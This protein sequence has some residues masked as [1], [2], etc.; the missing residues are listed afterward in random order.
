MT[1]NPDGVVVQAVAEQAGLLVLGNS[2]YPGWEAKVDGQPSEVLRVNFIQ[3]GVLVPAGEHRVEFTFRSATLRTGAW[4]SLLGV[5]VLVGLVVADRAMA[6]R[7]V[8][9]PYEP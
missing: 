7:R 4:L 5:A 8:A 6:R 9:K 3:R 1:I 2:F